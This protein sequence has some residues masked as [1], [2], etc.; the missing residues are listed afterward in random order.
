MKGFTF[1]EFAMAVIAGLSMLAF[2]VSAQ[3]SNRRQSEIST[4]TKVQSA[5]QT[6]QQPS[7]RQVQS[8]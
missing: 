3:Q 5:I 6:G 4:T 7:S 8:T 2:S 1:L